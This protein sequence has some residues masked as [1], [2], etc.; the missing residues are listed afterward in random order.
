M[1]WK[2]AEDADTQVSTPITRVAAYIRVSSGEQVD[3]WSLDG[4]EKEIRQHCDRTPGYRVVDVYREEGHSAWKR[5]ADIRPEYL[6]LMAD[7][8][9]GKFDLLISTSIDRMSRSITNMLETA[10]T[11]AE[12]NVA[13][14]SLQEDL[15]FTGPMGELMLTWLS[16]MSQFS[17]TMTSSHVK[18]ALRQRVQNGLHLSRPPFGYQ[19]CDVSC[20]DLPGHT[21]CHVHEEKAAKVVETFNLHSSGT[22]SIQALADRL[23]AHGYRT[24]GRYGDRPGRESHGNRFTVSSVSR[25]LRNRFYIGE[26]EYGGQIIKGQHVPILSEELFQRVQTLF[27]MNR[28]RYRF[29]GRRPARGHLL[30]RL[31]RCRECGSRLHSTAQGTQGDATY[32][33]VPR[34]AGIRIADTLAGHLRGT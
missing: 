20:T 26:L 21:G 30:S 33:R 11:L 16:S 9:A 17:S 34:S 32:Y 12:C 4:Q 10:E 3:T 28:E 23:H 24:N 22:Y 29:G 8:R 5:K 2:R 13:Y 7:A 31:V 1:S 25:M 6:R 15:D 18:R 14:K 19:I 27:E